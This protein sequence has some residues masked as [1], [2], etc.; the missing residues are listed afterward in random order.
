M[1]AAIDWSYRQLTSDEQ[2]LLGSLSVFAGGADLE[3]MT[4][5]CAADL[6]AALLPA[7][8]GLVEKNLLDRV[9]SDGPP[10]YRLLETIREYAAERLDERADLAELRERHAAHYAALAINIS[11]FDEGP[12]GLHWLGRAKTEADNL[13]ATMDHLTRT[14]QAAAALQ[15]ATD[16]D[17][18]WWD[19]GVSSSRGT[20]ACAPRSTGHRTTP[21]RARSVTWP[22]SWDGGL[23]TV[24]RVRLMCDSAQSSRTPAATSRSRHSPNRRSAW[25]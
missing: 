16:M 5:V 24:S 2:T 19:G 25:C 21:T 15:V 22:A 14:G 8:A 13:R 10:R 20:S 1:R 4:R 23:A 12:D 17:A 7:L 3:A 6:D 11:R 18:L 9:S